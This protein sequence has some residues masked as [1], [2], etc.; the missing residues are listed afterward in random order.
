MKVNEFIY[1][2][3][4]FE[5][6]AMLS[7]M[8]Y[9]LS[10]QQQEQIVITE[11]YILGLYNSIKASRVLKFQ[12]YFPLPAGWEP[13]DRLNISPNELYAFGFILNSMF[14]ESRTSYEYMHDV[15]KEYKL[16]PEYEIDDSIYNTRILNKLNEI[17]QYS[18]N[19]EATI[20]STIYRNRDVFNNHNEMETN[21]GLIENYNNEKVKPYVER[22]MQR[23][24]GVRNLFRYQMSGTM[25]LKDIEY[26][27][28]KEKLNIEFESTIVEV[29]QI[30]DVPLP[31]V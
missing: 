10:Y 31:Y 14:D 17:R 27:L 20:L 12:E 30:Y 28:I 8:T 6:K 4:L 21:F 3:I 16:N 23:I 19:I 7:L 22:E 1:M 29:C 13:E 5:T 25:P 24:I 11:D 18:N 2:F 9:I 15:M 26:N